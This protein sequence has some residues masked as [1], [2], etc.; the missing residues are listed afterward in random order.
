MLTESSALP[1]AGLAW[2]TESS[3]LQTRAS[4]E[5]LERGVISLGKGG[6]SLKNERFC[7][8]LYAMEGKALRFRCREVRDRAQA[9]PSR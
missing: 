1:T 4:G 3:A 2:L 7:G 5:F 6:N 9:R 8:R